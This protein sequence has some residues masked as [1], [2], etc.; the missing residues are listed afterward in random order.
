MNKMK[1]MDHFQ[2]VEHGVK[3]HEAFRYS[4]AL[5][6]L[7]RA[8]KSHPNC[9]AT[10]Y[11]L[12]NTLYMLDE[13]EEAKDLLVDLIKKST[14]ELKDGCPDSTENPESFKL[15][16]YFLL[17]CVTL[18]STGKWGKAYPYVREHLKRRRRGLKSVWSRR[19]ILKEIEELRAK[20][21]K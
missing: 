11:N 2:L 7:E 21:E 19:T 16:A 8:Y 10:V 13:F 14:S 12:A 20:F 4:K 6:L 3:H 15:D 17:F 5:P 9:P 18:Y 1:K